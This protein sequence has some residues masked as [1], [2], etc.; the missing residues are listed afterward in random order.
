MADW[1]ADAAKIYGGLPQ[2][3]KHKKTRV[4]IKEGQTQTKMADCVENIWPWNDTQR[5]RSITQQQLKKNNT[6]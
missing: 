5:D 3:N 4:H 6:P 1:A 2:Q